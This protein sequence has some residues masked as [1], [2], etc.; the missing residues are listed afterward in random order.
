MDLLEACWTK[1][2]ATPMGR[3]E[4]ICLIQPVDTADTQHLTA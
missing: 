1:K 2:A 3:L 4:V